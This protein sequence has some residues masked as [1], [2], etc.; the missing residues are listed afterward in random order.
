M[1]IPSSSRVRNRVYNTKFQF[2]H[3]MRFLNK[4]LGNRELCHTSSNLTF[5]LGDPL[6]DFHCGFPCINKATWTAYYIDNIF[7]S[8]CISLPDVKDLSGIRVSKCVTSDY[9]ITA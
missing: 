1:S 9:I 6:A 4:M 7:R 2:I 3:Y 5:M 8:T